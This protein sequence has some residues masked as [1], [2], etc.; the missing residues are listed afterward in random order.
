MIAGGKS[1]IEEVESAMRRCY[2]LT[3]TLGFQISRSQKRGQGRPRHTIE[4]PH[5]V[6]DDG[7][8][9]PLLHPVTQRTRAGD[10]GS[11]HAAQPPSHDGRR[12]RGIF[13]PARIGQRHKDHNRDQDGQRDY[14]HY[15]MVSD[16][17]M[18]ELGAG[19]GIRG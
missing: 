11:A 8:R 13:G 7:A 10:P 1:Q 4:I 15:Q 16:W 19:V 9:L 3:C 14:R 2:L 5:S 6:R 18:I 17:E 12:R